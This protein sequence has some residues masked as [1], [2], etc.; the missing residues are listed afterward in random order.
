MRLLY[1]TDTVRSEAPCFGV[2]LLR[3]DEVLEREFPLLLAGS[4]ARVHYSRLPSGNDISAGGLAAMEAVLPAA[5]DLLP[6]PVPYDVIALACTSGSTIIGEDR[7]AEAIRGVHPGVAVSNPMTAAKA[8]LRALGVRRI[9]F[10]T[11][12]VAEITTAMRDNLARNGVETV[13]FGSFGVADDAVVARMTRRSVLEAAL[14][15][16]ASDHCE[17]VFI[18]CTNL[19]AIGIIEEA[20]AKLGKPVICS[21]QALVWHMLRLAGDTAPRA[22]RGRLMTLPLP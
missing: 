9:G 22:G 18:S 17:A 1:E 14:T 15:I 16:G 11:P 19:P 5:V 2:V 12:Y 4:D 10:V 13:S 20:E 6:P 8:A 7:V 21:N 3:T